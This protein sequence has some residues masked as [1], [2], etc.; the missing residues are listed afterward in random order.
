ML[1]SIRKRV[2]D[3]GGPCVCQ[4][5][6]AT[7]QIHPKFYLS[8][9]LNPF[10]RLSPVLRP[11]DG[12]TGRGLRKRWGVSLILYWQPVLSCF[13]FVT[14]FL[15]A[16]VRLLAL[17]LVQKRGRVRLSAFTF[18]SHTCSCSGTSGAIPLRLL[19]GS[20][21]SSVRVLP[22]RIVGRARNKSDEQ[23]SRNAEECSFCEDF[24]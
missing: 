13:H 7:W 14:H 3:R 4:R 2:L 20:R 21:S 12:G 18:F 8:F 11:D 22:R 19:R 9:L 17:A 6:V 10:A 24:F 1:A 16:R 15:R 23:W 5:T